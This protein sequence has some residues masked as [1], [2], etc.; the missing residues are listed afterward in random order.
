VELLPEAEAHVWLANPDG[1]HEPAQRERCLALLAP[2]ERERHGRLRREQSRREFLV[3]HALARVTLS[4]YAPVPPEAW[5]FCA[6]EHGRP[7]LSGPATAVRL[8]FNLSHTRGMVACA[9]IRE[10]DI[11]VDVERV[12]RR[13]RHRELAER[14]FGE[15]EVRALRALAPESQPGRFLELWTLKEAYLKAR[16]RGISIS[17]RGFQ[18]QLS[19]TVPPR[20]RFDPA[21]LRDDAASWQLALYHPKRSHALAVAIHRPDRRDVAIRLFEGAPTPGAAVF[22]VGIG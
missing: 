3:A 18:F 22:P 1:I 15:D 14:F 12:T 17:L 10:L 20:I 19:E 6:G 4:R 5:S 11:G 7:E 16:G 9:V 13:V 8:R 21:R 2:E